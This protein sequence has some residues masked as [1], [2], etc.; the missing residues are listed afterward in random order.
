MALTFTSLLSMASQV[1]QKQAGSDERE[2]DANEE[3]AHH[4][5]IPAIMRL[6]VCVGGCDAFRAGGTHDPK[7][8]VWQIAVPN[9]SRASCDASGSGARLPAHVHLLAGMLGA[10]GSVTALAA[11][12]SS[13][14]TYP[15][16]R[17][18]QWL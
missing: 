11:M 2:H 12:G 13:R 10:D 8:A 4:P 14:S 15:T 17:L 5:Q 9:R 1:I 7:P 6:F 16:T 18:T 3:Q